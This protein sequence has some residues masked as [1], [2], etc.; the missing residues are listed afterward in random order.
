MESTNSLV[1]DTRISSGNEDNSAILEDISKLTAECRNVRHHLP[2]HDQKLY[3]D[4][5]QRL[6][7]LAE[8]NSKESKP[9]F[10]FRRNKET[11][12][13]ASDTIPISET[14]TTANQ[15]SDTIDPAPVPA[16]DVGGFASTAG[17]AGPATGTGPGAVSSSG[18][19]NVTVLDSNNGPE[20]VTHYDQFITMSSDN[21]PILQ[22]SNVRNSIIIL[23]RTFN[24]ANLNN[25][26]SSIIFLP[27]VH[28]PIH[29]SNVTNSLVI[30]N[31]HQF[32]I[33]QS[34]DLRIYLSCASKRPIIE[35][36]LRLGFG[37][38]PSDLVSATDSPVT[39][40]TGVDDFNWIRKTPSVNWYEISDTPDNFQPLLVFSSQPPGPLHD[41]A[42]D[43]LTNQIAKLAH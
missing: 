36:C 15:H 27:S 12:K 34:S 43:Y 21:G 38:Y 9:R 4:E 25:I 26:T 20:I 13:P 18:S 22:L 1:I 40:W 29:A 16:T 19:S 41:Q 23:K 28:G 24:S 32:R 39:A 5:L 8:K 6:T 30:A 35:H 17:G 14:Q 33:H 10:S 2:Q 3:S 42:K 7:D 31:C 11:S 37:Q